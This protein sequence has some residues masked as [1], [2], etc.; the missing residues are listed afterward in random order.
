MDIVSIISIGGIVMIIIGLIGGIDTEK[1]KIPIL[2][3]WIRWAVAIIG[4]MLL[5]LSVYMFPQSPFNPNNIQNIQATLTTFEMT[6]TAFSNSPTQTAV[7]QTA[8]VSQPPSSSSDILE[9][10]A[11]P[12]KVSVFLYDSPD[13]DRFTWLELLYSDINEITYKQIFSFPDNPKSGAGMTFRFDEPTDFSAYTSIEFTILLDTDLKDC[14]FYLSDTLGNFQ[15]VSCK[16]PFSSDNVGITVKIDNNGERLT[17]IPL[18]ENF[19]KLNLKFIRSIYF[20]VNPTT[21]KGQII[22]EVS[23]IKFRK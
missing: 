1:I 2:P 4:F 5:L 3:I 12:L 9:I 18:N 10:E 17:N 14:R 13:P 15:S 19:K 16:E 22:Y 23:D 7:P 21:T 11:M 8:I 20:V 6:Q